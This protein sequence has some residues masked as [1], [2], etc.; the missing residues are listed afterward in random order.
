MAVAFAE[1]AFIG[2]AVHFDVHFDYNE[3]KFGKNL[4]EGWSMSGDYHVETDAEGDHFFVIKSQ[5][6]SPKPLEGNRNHKAEMF[7]GNIIE[8]KVEWLECATR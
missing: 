2:Q 5:L 8:D 6:N 3:L 7:I 4:E 1:S